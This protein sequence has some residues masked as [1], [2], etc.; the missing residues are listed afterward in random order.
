MSIHITDTK[1]E[2]TLA[3]VLDRVG[4]TGD[5]GKTVQPLFLGVD[6]R[7]AGQVAPGADISQ[8]TVV[9]Q[10]CIVHLIDRV[11]GFVAPG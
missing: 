9:P 6:I 1:D 8:I 2:V 10:C 11:D 3:R 4:P 7:S 5:D